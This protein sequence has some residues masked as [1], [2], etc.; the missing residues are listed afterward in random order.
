MKKS[1][2]II[3]AKRVSRNN[4]AKKTGKTSRAKKIGEE[5]QAARNQ[6]GLTQK[7]LAELFTVS[8]MTISRW[9]TGVFPPQ[10]MGAIR[11]A[12]KYLLLQQVLDTD[13]LL[14]SIEQRRAEIDAFSALLE[15]ER[16][17]FEQSLKK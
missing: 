16:K 3:P 2:K 11:L 6:L 8:M 5:I 13:E 1:S 14:R 15:Q 9:E 4:R 10:A 17:D 7:R 12:L